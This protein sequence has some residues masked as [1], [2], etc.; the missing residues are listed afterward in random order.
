MRSAGAARSAELQES[1]GAS[2]ASVSRALAPLLK[3]GEVLKVGRG[4]TQAYVAPRLVEGIGTTPTVR[5]MKVDEAG[6]VSPFGVLIPVT[7]GRCWMEEEAE[8]ISALHGSLP[9]FLADM[10][11]DGFL[12]R[13]FSHAHPQ[14]R[15]AA[16]PADWSDD[17]VLKALCQV[18]DDLPGNLIV[19]DQSFDRFMHSSPAPRVVP[20]QYAALAAAAMSGALPGSSA[21]GEQPKFCAVREDGQPVIVKFSAAGGSPAEQRWGD[22]LVCEHL[23]LRTLHEH[24]VPAARST[25]SRAEGRTFLEVERFDRTREGRIGMV[26]MRSFD[27]EY[28]GQIDNWAAAAERMRTRGLLPDADTRRL[29]FLEAFGQLIGNTDRHYGN[30]SLVIDNG[31]WRIAPAYDMLPMLY[32]PTA[33]ELVEREFNPGALAPT[34]QTLEVWPQ[35]RGLARQYWMNVAAEPLVSDAF[36]AMAADHASQLEGPA[37]IRRPAEINAMTHPR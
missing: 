37:Q 33:S 1:S 2:Q 21:G 11:P 14:L 15:L 8:G 27:N 34:P 31:R 19:G 23:A 25:V 7:G 6:G 4:R 28:I 17:D 35:A 5:V 26:S 22:L 30:I 20:S 12:G 36:R 32:A 29:V 13:S 16:S 10:R 3:D 18:G 9:W 24:G